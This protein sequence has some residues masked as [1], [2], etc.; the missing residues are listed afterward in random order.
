MF[1]PSLTPRPFTG[2][3][4]GGSLEISNLE[5]SHFLDVFS[6]LQSGKIVKESI[7]DVIKFLSKNANSSSEDA[8]RSL[9]IKTLSQ[10]EIEKIVKEAV[11]NTDRIDK[12]IGV[13]MSKL[14]GKVEAKKVV[15][16]VKKFSKK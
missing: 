3:F 7:P 12:A 11:E 8:I 2:T 10:K 9:G 15:D 1:L 4:N 14:R 6:S 13:A 16:M 5:T